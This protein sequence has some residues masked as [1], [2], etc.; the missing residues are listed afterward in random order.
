V[1]VPVIAFLNTMG[2][3]GKT[4]LVYHLAWMFSELRV[5]VLAV[6]L[7]PQAN[8]T[9]AFFDESQL[10]IWQDDDHT[11]TVYRSIQPLVRGTGDI[12][13]PLPVFIED[14]LSILCG[15][16]S[17]SAFEDELSSQW[18]AALSGNERAFRVLSAFWRVIQSAAEAEHSGLILI[19]LGPNL[20]SINRAALIAA[21][22]VVVPLAP[23]LF[24]LQ[25]LRNLG[26]TFL[27]WRGE[28]IDRL[29]RRPGMDIALPEGQTQPLGYVLQQHSLRLDRPVT[30]YDRWF[31]QVPSDYRRYVL[32]ENPPSK[33]SVRD[34][35]HCLA[36]LKHYRSLMP[37]AQEA[38]KPMFHLKPADGAI[39]AHFKSAQEAHRDFEALARTIAARIG[40]SIVT[41]LS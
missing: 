41:D 6:D 22:Y 36:L 38:R 11:L 4:S 16:L 39:G 33:A 35:P 7:D 29:S 15:D 18:P 31:N 20:G 9:A 8:L 40:L 28:W 37:M 2:G 13:A 5:K 24:S 19:D 23:D 1:S 27:R 32:S 34:D 30:A 14:N 10:A 17:L 25:G 21:D 12:E 3:V 26:P